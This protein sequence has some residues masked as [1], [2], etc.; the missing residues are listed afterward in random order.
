[1]KAPKVDT[2][3]AK[4]GFMA[5]PPWAKGVIAI[6]IGVGIY[7]IVK[8]VGSAPKK[9]KAGAGNRDEDKEMNKEY[10]DLLTTGTKPTMSKAQQ[11]QYANQLHTAMDGY[12]TDEETIKRILCKSKNDAD[13]I[14]IIKSYGTREVSSGNWNPEPNYK[15]NLGG[16]LNSE[17][18]DY[19]ITA[20]NK[21]LKAKNIKH[22]I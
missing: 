10:D 4:T 18:S 20:V 14:G 12:G 5:L 22:R 17:L 19:W 7:V 11:S 13:I 2:Q 16:A 3:F 15:G 1:M 21:C 6:G 8:K 9:I